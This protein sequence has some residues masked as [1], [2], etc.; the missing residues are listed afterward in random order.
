MGSGEVITTDQEKMEM[1]MMCTKKG[2]S[3]ML[4]EANKIIVGMSNSYNDIHPVS[5]C[6]NCGASE[7]EAIDC[8]RCKSGGYPVQVVANA[9]YNK[10]KA[11]K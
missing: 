11:N 9:L 6:P 3:E 2:L 4:I 8:I 10:S 1:Y 5:E 7:K